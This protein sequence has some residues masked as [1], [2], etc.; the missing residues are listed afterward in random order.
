MEN[1]YFKAAALFVFVSVVSFLMW[2]FRG[3]I[4]A[5][6]AFQAVLM[7]L[8][9]IS[10]AIGLGYKFSEIGLSLEKKK[11]IILYS[12]LVILISFPL[13][14]YAS[15]LPEFQN[16]YPM[17][18]AE[19]FSEFLKFEFLAMPLFFFL[20]FFYR[21]FALNLFKKFTNSSAAAIILQNIPY[22]FIHW[23]KPLPE[24]YFSFLAGIIFAY[25]CLRAKS[26]LPGFFGHYTMSFIFDYLNW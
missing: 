21:G 9:P 11:E 26:F 6:T 19:G 25:I 15:R 22:F 23:G 24:L 13:M 16:F 17:F 18:F 7:L 3:Q 8:V 5:I 4:F 10:L 2:T 14:L 12:A 20:E 1:N